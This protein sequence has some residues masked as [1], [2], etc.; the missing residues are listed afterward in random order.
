MWS[1]THD[2]VV[3]WSLLCECVYVCSINVYIMSHVSDVHCQHK[4]ESWPV[5]M[6]GVGAWNNNTV[7]Q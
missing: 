4:Y 3:L 6:S 1:V 7:L 5:V 2:D